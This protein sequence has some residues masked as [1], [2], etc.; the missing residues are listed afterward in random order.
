MKTKSKL[1]S[2]IPTWFSGRSDGLSTVLGICKY[3]GLYSQCIVTVTA[4][5]TE[6]RERES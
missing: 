3:N 5:T 6:K 1:G 2:K 4:E